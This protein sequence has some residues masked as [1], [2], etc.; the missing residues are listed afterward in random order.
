M[1]N[2]PLLQDNKDRFVIFPVKH[3]DIWDFYQQ[4]KKALYTPLPEDSFE[5]ASRD[6]ENLNPS[7]TEFLPNFLNFFSA[8]TEKTSSGL[9]LPLLN[10][11][12]NPEATAFLRLQLALE[13][14]QAEATAKIAQK[15]NSGYPGNFHSALERQEKWLESFQNLNFAEQLLAASFFK[16]MFSADIFL[17]KEE[18]EKREILPQFC[19]FLG[20]ISD[21]IRLVSRFYRFLHDNHV[22]QQVPKNGINEIVSEV[23]L[24]EKQISAELPA[25]GAFGITAGKKDAL[26]NHLA[27]KFISG[28]EKWI[29]NSSEEQ[30]KSA[31]AE[32]RAG[33]LT[34]NPEKKEPQQKSRPDK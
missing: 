4:L 31:L 33:A 24:L 21:E 6:W 10:F 8:A 18:L 17:L 14:R 2:E 29:A 3:H 1:Q 30:E 20:K 23:L 11:V 15:V 25:T 16:T 12:K 13:T 9:T 22:L 19:T 32:K 5:T 34:K 28:N 27:E 7:E 26:L